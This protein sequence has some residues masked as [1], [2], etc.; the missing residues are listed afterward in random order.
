VDWVVCGVSPQDFRDPLVVCETLASGAGGQIGCHQRIEDSGIR[1]RVP[2]E[3]VC[4]TSFGSFESSA[5]VMS[6]QLD[7]L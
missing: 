3:L 7:D 4:Q 2:R 6:D 1:V 5:R